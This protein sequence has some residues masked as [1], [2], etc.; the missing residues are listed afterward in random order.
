MTDSSRHRASTLN[1]LGGVLTKRLAQGEHVRRILCVYSLSYLPRLTWMCVGTLCPKPCALKLRH[2]SKVVSFVVLADVNVKLFFLHSSVVAG[3]RPR[4][5]SWIQGVMWLKTLFIANICNLSSILSHHSKIS[6]KAK[7]S[8]VAT[9]S[10]YRLYAD[11]TIT[12]INI[13]A[14]QPVNWARYA[15]S[16]HVSVLCTLDDA[17]VAALVLAMHLDHASIVSTFLLQVC[18][19][20]C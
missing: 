5:H 10:A 13:T 19:N 2:P 4:P 20:D 8:C 18:S 12:N 9:L 16:L 17:K 15:T 14:F 11:F 3:L 7:A 1:A 6:F